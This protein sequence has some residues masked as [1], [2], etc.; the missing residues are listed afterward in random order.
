MRF[1]KFF[2]LMFVITAF[3]VIYIQLQVQIY[4]LA[5][6]GKST[7]LELQKLLDQHSE[8]TSN[9]LKLKSASH[10]GKFL[11]EN[12]KMRFLDNQHVVLLN[13]PRQKNTGE[14]ASLALTSPSEKRSGFLSSLFNLRAQAEAGSI[15]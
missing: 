9:I 4:D 6:K 12:S 14:T 8:V 7:E 11:N 5:Y 10:L 1:S 15:K 2:G 13:V 3:A